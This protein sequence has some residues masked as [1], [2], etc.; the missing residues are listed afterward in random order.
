MIIMVRKLRLVREGKEG[1]DEEPIRKLP[2]P[3]IFYN[4][5]RFF[6]IVMMMTKNRSQS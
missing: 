6:V 4:P 2:L 5:N 3:E 1:V